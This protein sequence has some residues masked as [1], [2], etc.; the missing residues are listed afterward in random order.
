MG[1]FK[2]KV[3]ELLIGNF[4]GSRAE[5]ELTPSADKIGGFLV[6]KGFEGEPHIDRQ[7]QVWSVLRKHLQREDQR[8]ITAIL[9]VSPAEMAGIR[10]EDF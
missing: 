8:K 3:Q 6:W 10:D 1:D 2:E 5:L 9:T 7:K 4:D